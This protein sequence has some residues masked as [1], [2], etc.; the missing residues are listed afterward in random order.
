MRR[1]W[2]HAFAATALSMCCPLVADTAFDVPLMRAASHSTQQGFVRVTALDDD[3]AL[4]IHAWDDGGRYRATTLDVA[5]RKT[6]HFNSD[7]LEA[8]NPGKGIHDGIGSGIGDWHLRLSAESPFVA[9]SYMRTVDG[10]LTAIGNVL[11]PQEPESSLGSFACMYEAAL[12]N[13][14]SNVNQES[15]LR[16]VERD[17]FEALVTV[18]GIDDNGVLGGPASVRVRAHG[19]VTLTARQ[20]ETGDHHVEGGLGDGHG[21][22]RLL[23]LTDGAIIALNLMQTPTGHMTNLGPM[24]APA[25][26]DE[27]AATDTEI[28]RGCARAPATRVVATPAGTS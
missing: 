28:V 19:A 12:F 9:T 18:F 13:P 25:Q 23:I 15:R 7:D 22:W 8:G 1:V 24:L 2:R 5:A 16:L 11:V 10:F 27:L 14:G 20:L 3:V 26:S 21:K 4:T 6:A 17:G